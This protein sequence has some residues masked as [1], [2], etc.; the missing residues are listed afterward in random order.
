DKKTYYA[1]GIQR[2]VGFIDGLKEGATVTLEGG[3]VSLPRDTDSYVLRVS[4][5]TLNGKVYDNLTPQ[6]PQDFQQDGPPP[7]R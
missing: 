6:P 1:A 2:L 3:A 5:L 4:K 7:R